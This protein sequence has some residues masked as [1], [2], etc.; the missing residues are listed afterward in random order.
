M[1]HRR[2]YHR[3]T[4]SD[5]CWIGPDFREKKLLFVHSA[6]SFLLCPGVVP[7]RI[8]LK[9]SADHLHTFLEQEEAGG[10]HSSPGSNQMCQVLIIS[11]FCFLL[12]DKISAVGRKHYASL[13]CVTIRGEG[14]S[15]W[16]GSARARLA[17][18]HPPPTHFGDSSSRH[19]R[20]RLGL[21][22]HPRHCY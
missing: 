4:I 22:S 3:L 20:S 17:Q 6:W 8:V 9:N 5:D 14:H 15:E 12:E 7:W 2:A 11:K 10:S 16:R 21:H 1:F 18:P 19:I 13:W